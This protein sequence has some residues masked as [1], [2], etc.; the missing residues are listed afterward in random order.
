[1]VKHTKWKFMLVLT[2]SLL[3][4][5]GCSSK[6]SKYTYKNYKELKK[7][8]KET[9]L[10]SMVVLKRDATNRIGDFEIIKNHLVLIDTQA[11]EV[12][13][14]FDLK[15]HELLKSFAKVG[16]GPSE[17]IQA[18]QIIPSKRDKSVFWVFDLSTNQ[19][20]KHNIDAVLANNFK[21]ENIIHLKEENGF[22]V[23]FIILPDEKILALG[24]YVNGRIDIFNFDGDIIRTIGKI[25]VKLRQKQ[26][27]TQH[28]HGFDGTFIYEDNSKEIFVAP[29]LGSVVEVYNLNGELLSTYHGPD[30][31]FPQYDIV[32]AGEYF[33]MTYNKKSRF[34]YLDI[35][36]CAKTDKLFLLY[37]GKFFK[38]GR[39]SWSGTTVYVLNNA[40]TIIKQLTLDTAV[41]QMNIS[42][43][44]SIL[45]GLTEENEIVSFEYNTKHGHGV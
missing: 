29:M 36:Y 3:L 10:E 7:P 13:K 34:G 1:M 6:Y 17:F 18:S 27:S 16:Q 43:D 39:S 15:T 2:I 37:S 5:S 22:A 41:C 42:D 19:L 28:S 9:Q 38:E 4:V 11:D 30:T 14:I 20:K 40:G 44:G 12:I 32:S 33:T 8:G 23:H 35:C 24:F 21:P 31:F 25:P 26:F 45:Y